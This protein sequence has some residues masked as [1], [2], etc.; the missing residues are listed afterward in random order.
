MTFFVPGNILHS[1]ILLY[2]YHV[3]VTTP[4]FFDSCPHQHSI[5]F[6][7]FSFLTGVFACKVCWVLLSI[8]SH[9]IYLLTRILR[10]F[11]F[12]VII[13]TIRFKPIILLLP[14]FSMCSIYSLFLFSSLLDFSLFYFFLFYSVGL[15]VTTVL[16]SCWSLAD[17]SL[18]IWPAS[19][20]R[21][22]H[23]TYIESLHHAMFPSS[24]PALYVIVMY[25]T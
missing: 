5:S 22:H 20:S 4:V 13:D 24:P 15:L 7:I 6:S 10:S 19:S 3:N 2:F 23:L 12:N 11:K 16:S 8:Q 21:W 25:F 14:I 17:Y 18:H 9:S 1:E